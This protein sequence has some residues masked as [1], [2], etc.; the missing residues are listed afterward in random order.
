MTYLL[1]LLLL[2]AQT[3]EKPDELPKLAVMDLEL[4]KG[5]DQATAEM[6]NEL[7]LERLSRSKQFGTVIGGSDLREMMSLEEQKAALGCEADSCLAELGGA[8]G[9][10]LMLS[11]SLGTFA[12][13]YI[14]NLKLIS[15]EDAKVLAR[16]SRVVKDETK[17][18][19]E[20][21]ASLDQVVSEGMVGPAAQTKTSKVS[22]KAPSNDAAADKVGSKLWAKVSGATLL[23]G[24]LVTGTVLNNSEDASLEQSMNAYQSGSTT[25]TEFSSDVERRSLLNIV[26]AGLSI[27]GVLLSAYG[28]LGGS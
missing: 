27:T 26:G 8:L 18:L 11:S 5:L 21:A 22:V 16:S 15:V 19:D 25:W 2:A 17:L 20:L 7:M 6:L 14:L 3:P 13:N 23:A 1:L 10:P 9:V 4:K 28:W 12:G 24:G